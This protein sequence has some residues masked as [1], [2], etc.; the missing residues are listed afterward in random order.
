VTAEVVSGEGVAINCSAADGEIRT[1][2]K[3]VGA[4]RVSSS[5]S[6]CV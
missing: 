5:S 2:S 1:V 6:G 4:S 3:A